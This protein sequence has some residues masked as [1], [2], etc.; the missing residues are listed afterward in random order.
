MALPLRSHCLM[1][2][3]YRSKIPGGEADGVVDRVIIRRR[4]TYLRIKKSILHQQIRHVLQEFPF[5]RLH[6]KVKSKDKFLFVNIS[7][8]GNGRYSLDTI[9]NMF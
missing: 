5:V 6:Y 9:V 2:I 3:L 7:I 1:Y 4:C 8:F